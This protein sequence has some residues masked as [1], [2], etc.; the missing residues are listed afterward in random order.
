MM[1]NAYV[2]VVNYERIRNLKYFFFSLFM[3]D[4]QG[5]QGRGTVDF[6]KTRVFDTFL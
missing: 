6:I 3:D 5:P 4:E 2:S 1:K